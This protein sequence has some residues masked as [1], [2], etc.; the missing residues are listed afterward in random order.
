MS[1]ASEV[2]YSIY[3]RREKGIIVMIVAFAALFSTFT[4]NIYFPAILDIAFDMHTPISLMNL[5]I[6]I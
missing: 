5:S 1:S 2:L 6:T 4:I 3:S